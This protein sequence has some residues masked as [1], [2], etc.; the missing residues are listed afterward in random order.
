MSR[1]RQT[2]D[3]L[4]KQKRAY[5][6]EIDE[7]ERRLELLHFSEESNPMQVPA[8]VKMHSELKAFTDKMASKEDLGVLIV[9]AKDLLKLIS[10]KVSSINSLLDTVHNDLLILD[11]EIKNKV[12]YGMDPQDVK[13]SIL[14]KV[15]AT[16]KTK[17]LS[18]TAG[19]YDSMVLSLKDVGVLG[20]DKGK[21]AAFVPIIKV[22]NSDFYQYKE[23]AK[24]Y[25]KECFDKMMDLSMRL[26]KDDYFE[27]EVDT[28]Y[29]SLIQRLNSKHV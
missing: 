1:S 6:M 2:E 29:S 20:S 21:P 22:M 17:I 24:L 14:K 23:T 12:T 11:L 25:Y 10:S 27:V 9:E 8:N 26:A 13:F 18:E 15:I 7:I 3:N 28:I 16:E 19:A 5:R 4:E